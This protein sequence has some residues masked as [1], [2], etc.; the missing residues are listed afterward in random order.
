MSIWT[1]LLFLH[2]HVATS[3]ALALLAPTCT[4]RAAVALSAEPAAAEA[5]SPSI[6]Q[7]PPV[8]HALRTVCQLR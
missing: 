1:D 8:H 4:A 2:G 7:P 3:A 6:P 5:S